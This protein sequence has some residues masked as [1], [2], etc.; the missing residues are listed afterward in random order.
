MNVLNLRPICLY[1]FLTVSLI[2]LKARCIHKKASGNFICIKLMYPFFEQI[3]I[4]YY[5][6]S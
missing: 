2:V 3:F 5:F 6:M 1:A 4:E